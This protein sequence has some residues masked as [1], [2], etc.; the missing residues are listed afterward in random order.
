MYNIELNWAILTQAPHILH[1]FTLYIQVLCQLSRVYHCVW[2]TSS[3]L[4]DIEISHL[5]CL[6]QWK[7]SRSIVTRG[8]QNTCAVCFF[9]VIF[10]KNMFQPVNRTRKIL[11]HTQ[12]IW[13]KTIVCCQV[14]QSQLTLGEL[15]WL[16]GFC[17]SESI[18]T[19]TFSVILINISTIC[20][21][22][23]Y[24]QTQLYISIGIYFQIYCL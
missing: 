14:Q 23:N 12:F 4:W 19:L 24:S 3:C 22:E 15:E 21:I 18:E 8:F 1:E 10:C 2:I 5:N 20:C 6:S 11:T 17:W 9:L 7:I 13:T 16:T